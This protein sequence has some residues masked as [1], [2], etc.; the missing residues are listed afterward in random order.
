MCGHSLCV[1]VQVVY[2]ESYFLTVHN[3]ETLLS[4]FESTVG[5]PSRGIHLSNEIFFLIEKKIFV[6]FNSSWRER[7][8][9]R[10]LHS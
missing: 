8:V 1:S 2:K 9:K 5:P 6:R 4:L 10:S 3:P 7:C